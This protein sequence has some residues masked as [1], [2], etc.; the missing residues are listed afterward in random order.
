MTTSGNTA[1]STSVTVGTAG[2]AGPPAW[3][4]AAGGASEPS[5]RVTLHGQAFEVV[6]EAAL[7]G[8]A[9]AV[10]HADFVDYG[11]AVWWP[12]KFAW[13]VLQ[14]TLDDLRKQN[15][16]V[17]AQT[18]LTL[19]TE[20]E[21]GRAV[22]K[23]IVTPGRG[24]VPQRTAPRPVKPPLAD[25]LEQSMGLVNQIAAMELDG[26]LTD[27]QRRAV[28]GKVAELQ[29]KVAEA[30]DM[31]EQIDSNVGIGRAIIME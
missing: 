7:D 2:T 21:Q 8:L 30:R 1:W 4:V 19:E 22:V 26:E 15:A 31:L 16:S 18:C 9:R 6:D 24:G 27:N 5:T 20:R 3:I 14:E 10:F 29:E 12:A 13:A 28:A 23:S 17:L 25:L 11:D